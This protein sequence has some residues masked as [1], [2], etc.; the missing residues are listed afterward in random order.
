VFDS[1]VPVAAARWQNRFRI[2]MA[3]GAD[4]IGRKAARPNRGTHHVTSSFRG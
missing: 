4:D 1:L 2:V 3:E